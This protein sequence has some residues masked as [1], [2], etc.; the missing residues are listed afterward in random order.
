[1]PKTRV[2]SG[3]SNQLGQLISTV[4]MLDL[5]RSM[6]T[7]MEKEKA[8]AK[9][10]NLGAGDEGVAVAHPWLRTKKGCK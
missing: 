8:R 10:R 3:P 2:A 9:K 5:P 4:R 6:V 7:A 1:V